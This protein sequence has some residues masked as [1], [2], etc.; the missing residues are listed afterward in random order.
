MGRWTLFPS[1]TAEVAERGVAMWLSEGEES[2]PMETDWV[3]GMRVGDVEP[4]DEVDPRPS[5]LSATPLLAGFGL[6][7]GEFS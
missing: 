3:G 4:E 2:D 6:P 1:P 5:L 7:A